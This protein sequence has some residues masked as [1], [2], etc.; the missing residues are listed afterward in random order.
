MKFKQLML[1]GIGVLLGGT[2][3]I[4]TTVNANPI[5][6]NNSVSETSSEEAKKIM[7]NKVPGAKII[8]FEFDIDGKIK[9]M[10]EL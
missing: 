1:V 5:I 8:K 7:L 4:A 2:L 10:M 3:S 6:V 9:N